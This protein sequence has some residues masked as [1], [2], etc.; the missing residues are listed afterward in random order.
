MLIQVCKALKLANMC[1][2]LKKKLIVDPQ[3]LSIMQLMEEHVHLNH[4]L[5]MKIL[6]K[7]EEDFLILPY[8]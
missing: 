8:L 6:A 7:A 2:G 5:I 4:L 3:I 1:Q